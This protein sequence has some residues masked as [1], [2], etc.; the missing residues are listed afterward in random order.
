MTIDVWVQ[1]MPPGFG[2]AAGILA[3]YGRPEV[4][5]RGAKADMLVEDMDRFEVERAIVTC[6]DNDLVLKAV[7]AHPDRLIGQVHGD[8]TDIMG[9]VREL[10]RYR[11]RGFVSLR[12]EPFLWGKPPTDRVYYPLFA[13]CV[14][15]DMA[16]QTQVGQTGPMYPSETGRP[17]Y[18]DEV[19]LDF[20]ELRI[21]CGHLGWPWH[22][23]MIAVAW[24]H[25]N[26]FVDTSAHYPK[27][28]PPAFVHYLKTFGQDKVCFATDW[29]VLSWDRVHRELDDVLQLN[30]D[31]R[32]KFTHDNARRAFKLP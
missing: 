9:M 14:E 13:K 26:V 24:K 18:I 8:P 31:V 11:D 1:L 3:K 16:V 21:V 7:R 23:E 28:F 19:A 25:P 15:L 29:P 5:E 6:S 4:V 22:D 30:P 27:H 32:R 17:L 12:I 20:P 10:E 2:K